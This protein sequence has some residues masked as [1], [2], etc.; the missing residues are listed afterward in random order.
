MVS[1]RNSSPS[2]IP[3]HHPTQREE[4]RPASPHIIQCL[5][6]TLLWPQGFHNCSLSR[7]SL[8]CN[9]NGNELILKFSTSLVKFGEQR[10]ITRVKTADPPAL[11]NTLIADDD[12]SFDSRA[13][14]RAS[15][16]M[17]LTPMRG[18]LTISSS[19]L[20]RSPW[21]A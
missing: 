17:A 1:I 5:S 21:V 18:L 6:A 3:F 7:F 12:G 11:F 4:K 13:I 20:P 9:S 10:F 14:V 2:V 15:P 8:L 16:P 19:A